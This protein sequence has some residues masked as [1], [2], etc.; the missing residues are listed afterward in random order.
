MSGKCPVFAADFSINPLNSPWLTPQTLNVL[1]GLRDFAARYSLARP[2]LVTT[3]TITAFAQV[4]GITIE[5]VP[6]AVHC[7]TIARNLLRIT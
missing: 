5:F 3:R 1:R 4:D 7:Y 2:P 6:V